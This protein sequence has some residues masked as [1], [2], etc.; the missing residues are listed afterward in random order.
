MNR[1]SFLRN[2]FGL[3]AA[4]VGVPTAAV[5]YGF[6]ESTRLRIDRQTIAVPRLPAAF[7]GVTVAFVTDIHHGRSSARPT[8]PGSSARRWRWPRT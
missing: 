1:R 8:W 4:A 3:G 2:S 7:R 5:G 6:A